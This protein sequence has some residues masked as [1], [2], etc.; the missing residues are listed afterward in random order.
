MLGLVKGF[1]ARSDYPEW[2][3]SAAA[4]GDVAA[5]K[6]ACADCHDKY[7]EEYKTK[8]GSKAPDRDKP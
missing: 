2:E 5:T 3:K 4:R 7:R 6:A 8:Y 1:R